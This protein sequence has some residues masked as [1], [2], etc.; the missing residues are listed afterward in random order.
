MAGVF[1]LVAWGGAGGCTDPQV[2]GEGQ[3]SRPIAI[4]SDPTSPL[5]RLAWRPGAACPGVVGGCA[6]FCEGPPDSCPATACLPVLIDSGTPL[7]ILPSSDGAMGFAKECVEV[8]AA[9][10]LLTDPDD[11]EALAAS[12]AAFRFRE[13]P[14]IRAPGDQIDG[15]SWEAGDDRNP[16]GIGGVIGGN[17][18]RDFALELRHLA[19]EQPSIAWFSNYP[20]S[21]AVLG[22]QGRA[23]IRL[24]FPGRLLGRLL[25]DRCEIGPGLDCRLSSF[26]LNQDNQSLL[27]ESTRALVDA[28]VAPPPC[29]VTRN[30]DGTRCRLRSGGLE[31]QICSDSLGQGATL[32]VAT[33]V[34]GLVLFEDSAGQLLGPLDGLPSCDAA[35]FDAETPACTEAELGRLVLPGWAPLEQLARVRVRS[36]GLVEGLTQPSGRNPCDRLRGRLQGLVRQCQG[37]VAERRPVRPAVDVGETVGIS[38]TVIGEVVLRPEQTSPDPGAWIEALI[39]PA[40]AAPVIALRR[41]VVPEGA[42]PDGLIGGALLTNTETVLDFTEAIENPGV[43]V[44]CLD[45][46]PRCLA[47]PACVADAGTV[48]FPLADAGRTSCCFGLPQELIA[49]VVLGGKDK[50]APRVEDVCCLALSRAAITDLQTPSLD[51]C[52]GYDLP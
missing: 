11:P 38:V 47:A 50:Q 18:L 13:A 15:W 21:E 35:P 1:A 41:E 10:G 7:S 33:G 31:P 48:D 32:V 39:V 24:Q 29:A 36:L 3:F 44:R 30:N 40:T 52:T 16:I 45:P 22:D 49:E 51:L 5:P 2:I 28:C 17:I 9:G 20:G 14:M 8:R 6:S 43:R 37:F 26:N 4:A 34:P 46:G 23:Y 27:F 25:S 42:Q 12:T 19:G